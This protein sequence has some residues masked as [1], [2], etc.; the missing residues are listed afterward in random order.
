MF[1]YRLLQV[2]TEIAKLLKVLGENTS[3]NFHSIQEIQRQLELV[4]ICS[5]VGTVTGSAAILL[6]LLQSL[7]L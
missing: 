2:L 3:M 1:A 7:L 5:V 4:L 6:L